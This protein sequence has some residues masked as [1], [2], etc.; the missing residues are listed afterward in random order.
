MTDS[1]RHFI[2]GA[3]YFNVRGKNDSFATIEYMK[4]DVMHTLEYPAGDNKWIELVI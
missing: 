3:L 4:K 2:R 1:S